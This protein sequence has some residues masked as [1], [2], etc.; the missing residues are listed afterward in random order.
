MVHIEDWGAGYGGVSI[1]KIEKKLSEVVKGSARS[2]RE[3]ELLF[4]IV[5]HYKPKTILEFGT[6][7][8][9]SS[10]FMAKGAPQTQLFS[11]EG[12]GVLAEKARA[13]HAA[14]QSHP[15]IYAST[16]EEFIEQ[17]IEK[18]PTIDLFFLDGNHRKEPTL[19]YIEAILP[20]MEPNGIIILDDIRWSAEMEEAWNQLLNHPQLNVTLDLFSMGICFVNRPQAREH[21]KLRYRPF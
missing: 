4:R 5:K 14:F 12:S 18:L 11:V 13:N 21:F 19:R 9:F 1:P 17:E 15:Q 16:F 10:L 7:L 8:G 20:K 6:N 2:R 3:G